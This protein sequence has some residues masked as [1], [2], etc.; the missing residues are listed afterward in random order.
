MESKIKIK[1][2]SMIKSKSRGG[3]GFRQRVISSTR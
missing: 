1:S 2:K 3:W